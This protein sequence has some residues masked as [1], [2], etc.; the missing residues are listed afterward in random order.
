MSCVFNSSRIK[1]LIDRVLNPVVMSD[2]F[3]C[4]KV[5]CISEFG[6]FPKFGRLQIVLSL[7][8]VDFA[9]VFICYRLTAVCGCQVK[10]FVLGLK[11]CGITGRMASLPV[12]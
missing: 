10:L 1:S 6:F 8:K 5:F 12:C 9:L 7:I 2:E 11:G 4:E 3:F